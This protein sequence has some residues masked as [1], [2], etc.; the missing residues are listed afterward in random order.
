MSKM[1][2]RKPRC[3]YSASGPFTKNKKGMQISKETGN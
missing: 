2:L 3:A 1:H